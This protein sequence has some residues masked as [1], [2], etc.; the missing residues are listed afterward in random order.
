MMGIILM[1]GSIAL[2]LE[3]WSREVEKKVKT[4][5]AERL[6]VLVTVHFE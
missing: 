1:F 5:I 6:L 3:N 4:S 2:G